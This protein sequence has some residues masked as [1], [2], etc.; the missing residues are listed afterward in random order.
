[1]KK[2]CKKKIKKMKKEYKK[3]KKEEKKKEE[4][5]C[6][7]EYPELKE[8]KIEDC[9]CKG[10]SVKSYQVAPTP[11]MGGFDHHPGM[12]MGMGGGVFPMMY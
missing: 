5:E 9:G 12:M 1:M 3:I 8:F 10:E 11:H 7:E 4:E 2:K 6:E